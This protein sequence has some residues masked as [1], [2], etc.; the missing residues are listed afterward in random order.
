MKA[1]IPVAGVGT[2]LRPH[3][4]TQPKPLLP[5]AG[6]PIISFIIDQLVEIGIKDYVFV[7]GYLGDKIMNYIEENH[8]NINREYVKQPQRLG[9]GHAVWTAREQFAK[10]DELFIVLGDTIFDVDLKQMLDKPNSVLGIKKVDDPRNFGVAEMDEDGNVVRVVEKPK[11]PKSNMALVGLYK[12]TEV[13]QLIDALEHIIQ[14][15]IKT[16]GEFQLTDGI[17]HMIDKGAKFSAI[18]VNNWFDCGKKEV[19]LETNAIL[20]G[21]S[22]Y[23]SE[24]L[25]DFENSIIIHPVSIAKGCSINNSIVGPNVTVAENTV[26]DSS[27]VKNSIIGHFS[28]IEG[29]VL[30]SSVIGNDASIK[31]LSQSLNIGD[32]NEI[33]FS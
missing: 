20:L 29:V 32:N 15:N 24:N 21:K 28:R 27:I 14:N 2:R 12:C 33:H 30:H 31:G 25:P 18:H 22:G 8:Q 19:L 1:L 16:R 13:S 7:I 9:L 26:I 6:K 11:I 5:V 10:E 4:Y 3:T 17:Q 23:A